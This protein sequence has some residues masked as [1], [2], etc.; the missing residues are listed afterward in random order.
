[1]K[2]YLT[3]L[4]GF[5]FALG[6][7]VSG[8]SNPAKVIHFL[9]VAGNWDPSLALVMMGAVPVAFVGFRVIE[10]KNQT[11]FREEL[12]LPGTTHINKSLIGG[13]VVFGV[14]WAITGF[15]P[16]PALVAVSAGSLKAGVFVLAMLI[17]MYLHDRFKRFKQGE[18]KV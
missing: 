16:G 6:L 1:M 8:M 3:L 11:F 10:V 18:K 4:A 13:G 14:G 2:N 7:I 15:C 9:D 5:V 12:H 17:G